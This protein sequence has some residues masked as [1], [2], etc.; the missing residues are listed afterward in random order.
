MRLSKDLM[1]DL[2]KA[3]LPLR[4]TVRPDKETRSE[5]QN[6]LYW[7]WVDEI[8]MGLE[9]GKDEVHLKLAFKFLPT[10][11]LSKPMKI[12]G[13]EIARW[14]IST[15]DLNTKDF[16]E[17]LNKIEALAATE[18]GIKLTMPDDLYWQAL[19]VKNDS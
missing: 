6:R 4:M 8:A 12:D 3:S 17:Y 11:P 1:S 16:A 14:P 19:G 18:L 5:K 13:N 10:N 7:K 15:R 9:V 2:F